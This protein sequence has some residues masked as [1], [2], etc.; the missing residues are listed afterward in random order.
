M[1]LPIQNRT[2]ASSNNEKTEGVRVTN[3]IQPATSRNISIQSGIKPSECGCDHHC[4]GPCVLGNC[5][6]TCTPV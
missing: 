3:S 1:K 5:L 4:L 6:G 2:Q